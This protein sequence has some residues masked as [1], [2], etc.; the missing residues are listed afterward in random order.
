KLTMSEIDARIPQASVL[1][2][3]VATPWAAKGTA[4]RAVLE[5]AGNREVDTTD[6]VRVVEPDGRWALV[7]PDPA[8]AVTDVW[9][10]AGSGAPA[11]DRNRADLAA[12]VTGQTHAVDSLAR[13]VAGLRAAVAQLR[14]A[15]LAGSAAGAQLS[16]QI[17]A[18]ELV[19]GTA[20]VTGP[21]LL[22]TLNDAP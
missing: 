17:R 2:R 3:S 16:A 6:G 20:A 1:R 22:V 18:A 10:E 7:L 19:S 21:G 9:A 12:T 15:R 13:Q 11:A 4:M 8:E 5:A 14:D